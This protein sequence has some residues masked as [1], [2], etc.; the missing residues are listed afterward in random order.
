VNPLLAPPLLVFRA[1]EDLHTIAKLAPRFLEVA[2]R[3][4][5]R[6]GELLAFGERVVDLGERVLAIGERIDARGDQ[7]VELADQFEALG[8]A[9]AAEAR[10][11]QQSASDVV[12]AAQEILTAM[13]LIEQAIA[14]GVPLEGTIER[15]GRIVDRLPGGRP[16]AGDHPPGGAGRTD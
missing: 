16:R 10:A 1:L 13:P 11:T 12:K 6:G 4:D 14:L 5:D 2:E 9:I 3:I 8:N 15:I 7:I